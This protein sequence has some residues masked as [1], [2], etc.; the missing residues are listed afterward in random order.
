[1]TGN[2][3]TAFRSVYVNRVG[4]SIYFTEAPPR[5]PEGSV[6]VREKLAASDSS[7]PLSLVVMV[8]RGAGFNPAGGDWEYISLN[9]EGTIV[10]ERGPLASCQSCHVKQ[11]EADFVFRD[12]LTKQQ[13]LKEH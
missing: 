11:K 4:F 1:M 12:H 5:F 13:E 6:I 7:T 8:K 2:Q 10:R 9:G 3:E